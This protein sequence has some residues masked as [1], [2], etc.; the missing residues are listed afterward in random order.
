MTDR[1]S[2]Q[3]ISLPAFHISSVDSITSITNLGF[4]RAITENVKIGED[5][6]S[7]ISPIPTTGQ[8]WPRNN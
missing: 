6:N 7:G 1:G 8:I 5:S 3:S 4:F 2:T